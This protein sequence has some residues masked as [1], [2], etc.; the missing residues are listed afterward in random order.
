L[1][2]CPRLTPLSLKGLYCAQG[3]HCGSGMVLSINPTAEK[4]QAKF[5]SDAIA[6]FG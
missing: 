6:K 3:N 2:V 5:Q 1:R 4:T